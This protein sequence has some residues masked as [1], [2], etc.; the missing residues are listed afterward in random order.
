MHAEHGSSGFTIVEILVAVLVLGV[1]LIALAGS[2]AAVTRMLGASRRTTLAAQ[3]AERRLEQLR[4]TA[5]SSATGCLALA[6][7]TQ[8]YPDGMAERWDIVPGA[9][10][11]LIRVVTTWPVGRGSSTDTVATAVACSR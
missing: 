1:G 6:S 10:A 3:A 8:A 7:G 2:S 9:A 5:R 4:L 11:V